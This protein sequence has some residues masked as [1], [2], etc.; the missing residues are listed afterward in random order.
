MRLGETKLLWKFDVNPK[1]SR[2]LGPIDKSDRNSLVASPVV[3][4][5]RVYIAVG[6]SPEEGEGVGRLWCIDATRRGDISPELV[7][8]KADPDRPIAHKRFQACDEAAGDFV[9]P[10]P[11][12]GAVWEYVGRKGERGNKDEAKGKVEFTDVMHRTIAGVTV[13]DDLVLI[14]DFPGVLHCIDTKTGEACWT[15]DLAA[16]V[17]VMPT[18]VGKQVFVGTEEGEVVVVE[19]SRQF[20][21]LA[22]SALDANIVAAPAVAGG[23]MIWASKRHLFSIGH[24]LEG[25]QGAV[26]DVGQD[27]K[28]S[29]DVPPGGA[30]GADEKATGNKATDAKASDA[31]SKNGKTTTGR[32]TGQLVDGNSGEPLRGVSVQL[33]GLVGDGP[34]LGAPNTTTAD[35]GTFKFDDLKPGTYVVSIGAAPKNPRLAAELIAPLSIVAGETKTLEKLSMRE[36]REVRVRVTDEKSGAAS[37]GVRVTAKSRMHASELHVAAF[38]SAVTDQEGLVTFYLPSSICELQI[39]EPTRAAALDSRRT[40][41]LSEQ[42]P[43]QSRRMELKSRVT[44]AKS[45]GGVFGAAGG[46]ASKAG[47]LTVQLKLP[48]PTRGGGAGE[49]GGG[50]V[51]GAGAGDGAG[52]GAGKGDSPPIAEHIVRQIFTGATGRNFVSMTSLRAGAR[53]EMQYSPDAYGRTAALLIDV[54]GYE[55][56]RSP[57][58]QIAATMPVLEVELKHATF[59]T[60]QG[61]V[62]DD[63]DRPIGDARVRVRRI[64]HG[65]TSEFP[66]GPETATDAEGRFTLRRTRAGEQLVVVADRAGV[67]QVES[68]AFLVARP[69]AAAAPAPLVL[70]LAKAQH[71]ISGVV[72]DQDGIGVQ[73]ATVTHDGEPRSTTQTDSQGNF[74]LE[75]LP[76]GKRPLLVVAPT[77]DR[78]RHFVNA[79]ERDARLFVSIASLFNRPEYRLEL[80]ARAT[81]GR[82][83]E[84]LKYFVLDL[85]EKRWT[86]S[87]EIK[88][89]GQ[90]GIDLHTEMRLHGDHEFAVVARGE[91]FI[92]A[93]PQK[94]VTKPQLTPVTLTLRPARDVTLRGRVIDQGKPVAGASV[95]LSLELA[96]GINDEPWRFLGLTTK[97]PT[98]ADDGTFEIPKLPAGARVAVYVND[99]TGA[100][101][102]S[103]RV[104]L[105]DA[106]EFTLPDLTLARGTRHLRGRVVA[107]PSSS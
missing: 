73:G 45:P 83:P 12:S 71:E 32:L 17:W 26:Q 43:E 50:A 76:P 20:K 93:A 33:R 59:V 87:G 10:N 11:N 69:L 68:A 55:P 42:P 72:V 49:T 101:V 37:P 84:K 86:R 35:D 4:G 3:A 15:A 88:T 64:F 97:I 9:R 100:G 106:A 14:A 6:R 48:L 38:R 77:G 60:I 44:P 67:G 27:A 74:R 5:D 36:G 46:S 56:V 1:T 75:R 62:V 63:D 57:E 89:D 94:L 98:T 99:A 91:Q 22:Q 47:I 28:P 96:D 39:D 8:N 78:H 58:F 107:R 18:V 51:D 53:F 13:A 23:R 66:W 81:E 92:S 34:E 82:L 25:Q 30:K 102:W 40:L 61:R 16:N 21:R 95:G 7:F 31:K 24:R 29:R 80:T 105:P 54:P 41:D 2:Y 90:V 70:K 65:L 85:T 52:P 79:G 104:T 103:S 19:L